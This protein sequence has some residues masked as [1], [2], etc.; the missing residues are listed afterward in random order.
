MIFSLGYTFFSFW[1]ALTIIIQMQK[2]FSLPRPRTK[3]R[4]EGKKTTKKEKGT[5]VW[6][7]NKYSLIKT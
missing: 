7:Y 4:R 1:S 5:T 3:V 6:L 2:A